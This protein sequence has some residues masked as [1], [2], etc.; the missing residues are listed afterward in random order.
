MVDDLLTT[1][2]NA[3]VRVVQV[4][5]EQA[6]FWLLGVFVAALVGAMIPRERLRRGFGEGSSFAFLAGWG[7][8]MLLP[9]GA[10]G[11]LPLARL[12]WRAG[13]PKAAVAAMVCTGGAFDPAAAVYY[14]T[15]KTLPAVWLTALLAA[16]LFVAAAAGWV[17]ERCASSEPSDDFG[18]DRPA[19]PCAT[20]SA[21]LGTALDAANEEAWGPALREFGWMLIGPAL[22]GALL[23]VDV[24]STQMNWRNPLAPVW[25]APA[26]LCGVI[27]SSTAVMLA[28][29]MYEHGN[30]FAAMTGLFCLGAGMNLATF[31]WLARRVGRRGAARTAA[32]VVGAT[33]L[34]GW[35]VGGAFY[36]P[37]H[38]EA[39][40]HAFDGLGRR[41][42][43][44]VGPI[45]WQAFRGEMENSWTAHGA[46]GVAT[47][48]VLAAAAAAG[49]V[50]RVRRARPKKSE[51]GD[52]AAASSTSIWNR[53]LSPWWGA[54]A[55]LAAAGLTSLC[56]LWIYYPAPADLFE[57]LRIARTEAVGAIRLE[58]EDASERLADY[59]ELMRKLPSG[60]RLRAGTLNPAQV[61]AL[62][63]WEAAA[64]RI[65]ADLAAGRGERARDA[66]FDLADA[67]QL[68][69]KAFLGE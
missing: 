25:M 14:L 2:A 59:R 11:L 3:A 13:A 55:G 47:L 48:A 19:T 7:W 38:E 53:P 58:A 56:G 46:Y 10:V 60:V 54:L 29:E 62:A 42:R 15:M 63:V 65:E 67:H 52:A 64:V 45:G 37:P 68:C 20:G 34:F 22:V 69:R 49:A 43:L 39:H 12:L 1:A 16:S 9:L 24:F 5:L 50:A 28:G 6:P 18:L 21:R 61:E 33:L 41:F 32:A 26:A 66:V 30:S 36:H 51:G 27:G 40:T 4:G 17:V 57:E 31:A 44:E 35:S 23:P 8:G